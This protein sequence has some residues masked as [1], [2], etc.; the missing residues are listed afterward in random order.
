MG[1]GWRGGCLRGCIRLGR[2]WRVV[3]VCL[4]PVL[5][6][7]ATGLSDQIRN[8]TDSVHEAI[9]LCSPVTREYLINYAR[10]LIY[11][12]FMSFPSLAAIRVAYEFLIQGHTEPVRD[13]F[14]F[15]IL[16][17]APCHLREVVLIPHHPSSPPT[18]TP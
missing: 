6:L 15:P 17:P 4:V 3:E 14:T 8:G 9:I 5:A 10:P 16:Q 13:P 1:L 12:T 18:S 7:V 11:T 2:R